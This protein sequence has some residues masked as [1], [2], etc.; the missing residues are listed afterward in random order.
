MWRAVNW[1]RVS[2]VVD[3]IVVRNGVLLMIDGRIDTY[4]QCRK[5]NLPGLRR[6]LPTQIIKLMIQRISQE[7]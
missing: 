3:E 7:A 5:G 1:M 4:L 6:R 2:C